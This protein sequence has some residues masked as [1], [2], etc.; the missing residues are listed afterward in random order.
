VSLAIRSGKVYIYH[1]FDIADTIDLS[2]L[3]KLLGTGTTVVKLVARRPTPQYI[4][5][6]NPPVSVP[7]GPQVLGA[8]GDRIRATVRAK[9][10]DYGVASIIWELESPADWE[11]LLSVTT[12][13]NENPLCE[14]QSRQI[15]QDLVDRVRTA[16]QNPHPDPLL[17]DYIVFYFRQLDRPLTAQG[18]LEA[19]SEDLARMMRGE[20]RPLSPDEIAEALRQRISYYENDLVIIDWNTAIIIDPEESTEHLDILEF[21]N[22]ELLELRYYDRLLDRELDSIYA[23]LDRDQA[24]W[25]LAGFHHPSQKLM[26]LMVD[27]IELTEKIENA[28]KVIGDLYSARIY[29]NIASRLRLYEWKQSVDSKLQIVNQ[30]Y[31][32]RIE[33]SNTFRFVILE[34]IIILLIALEIVMALFVRY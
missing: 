17:E 6:L 9:F 24:L 26:A 19:S 7:L 27:V 25:S 5:F 2:R 28:I 12:A 29:R 4:Q 3:H 31:H 33:R 34:V 10:F 22:T 32:N 16:L 21:A 13:I 23:S 15:L 30:I 1:L 18:L 14:N 20:A 8:L 11:E